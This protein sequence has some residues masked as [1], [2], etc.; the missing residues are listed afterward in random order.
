MI[1]KIAYIFLFII[2]S[3][4]SLLWGQ[5]FVFRGTV[6]DEQTHKALDYATVQLFVDKQIVYGGIT[7]ANGHFELL[8]I[9][10]GTYR[11]IV[12]YLGYDSTE[13]EVKVIGDISAIFYLK[14]S[15][16][17]LN[18]VVVTASE[19]KRATS[20]SIVDRTAMKH[21]Q[22]SSFSDLM[23]LVPGGKSADP[24]MG[25]ANLIRIRETGKTE[26]IS[27]LGVGFYID[28]ISQNTD[29]NLQYM[30]NSTSAVNATSTMSKGMDMRTISTDNIEKVEIIRGIPSVAYGNVANGAVIIQRKMNESPLSARFK[31]DKT[32]KLFSVGKG[33]EHA[34]QA[35]VQMFVDNGSPEFPSDEG[36]RLRMEGDYS[37]KMWEGL[38]EAGYSAGSTAIFRML[39]QYRVGVDFDHEGKHLYSMDRLYPATEAQF[40]QLVD[41]LIKDYGGVPGLHEDDPVVNKVGITVVDINDKTYWAAYIIDK[42]QGIGD[43]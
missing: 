32:S 20:A 21:L 26:D 9:H 4:V 30:P 29:A 15:V 1:C 40:Q 8:H 35:D 12:S 27:S 25:Q 22:P 31:A 11:V 36:L 43:G 38:N 17:A 16:M 14:P 41:E 33:L 18:E 3:N 13:K 6:L 42:W 2:C 5:T 19:S 10:P 28:G 37:A 23:E 7:D 34:I 24:Q 39:N